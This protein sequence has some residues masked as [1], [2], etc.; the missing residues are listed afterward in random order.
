MPELCLKVLT[1]HQIEQIH[2]TTLQVLEKTGVK[3]CLPRAVEMLKKAGA[4]VEE[5]D[6]VH[7]PAGLVEDAVATS[8][9]SVTVF[10]RNGREAMRLEDDRTH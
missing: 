2:R 3:V 4:E 5:P 8:P 7:I 6:R 9:K 1:Q 10:N